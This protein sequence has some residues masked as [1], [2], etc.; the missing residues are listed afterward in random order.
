[1]AGKPFAT[2]AERNAEPILEVLT[3][4]FRDCSEVLEIGSGTG[5][6]AVRFAAALGHLDWQSS[7][8]EENHG[9]INAWIDGSGLK[10]VRAPLLLDVR[11]DDV[12]ASAYDA[13]Y[14][15][16]TAHIMSFE[17]VTCMFSLV[18]RALRPNGI[19]CLYGPFRQN[20]E[21]ST[22]SNEQFDASLRSRDPAMG[23]RDLGELDE[24]AAANNLVRTGLYAMPSNNMIALWQKT[25]RQFQ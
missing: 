18:G 16:N 13:V 24:L 22:A 25:T 1:M 10:S 15:A 14:S 5:Q 7:D 8:M 12:R 6:H 23:M 3:H 19:F 11:E 21:F 20:G 9:G 2:S 17:A 4:E